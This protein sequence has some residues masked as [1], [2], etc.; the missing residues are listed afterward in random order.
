M[1]PPEELEIF[2]IKIRSGVTWGL[3]VTR[4]TPLSVRISGER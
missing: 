4:R 1:V 2:S 3:Q